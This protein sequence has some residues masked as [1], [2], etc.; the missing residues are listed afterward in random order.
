MKMYRLFVFVSLILASQLGHA[1]APASGLWW[2]P[3]ESGRGFTIDTQGPGI[4]IVT[5]YVY[6]P[7]GPATW[8][9]TAGRTWPQ[10]GTDEYPWYAKTRVF[11]PDQFGDWAALMPQVGAELAKFLR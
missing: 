7:S 8:F 3:N 2:N 11:S 5:A 4:M 1:F 6:Q 9:L 10:L